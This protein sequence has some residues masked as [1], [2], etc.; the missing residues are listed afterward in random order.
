MTIDAPESWPGDVVGGVDRVRDGHGQAAARLQDAGG[1]A[2]RVRHAVDVVQAHVG[3]DQVERS[4]RER[5]PGHVTDHRGGRGRQDGRRGGQDGGGVG[6]HHRV[7]GGG[8]SPAD[9]ALAAA[10]VKGARP[11]TGSRPRNAGRFMS[12]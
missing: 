4:V 8:Q 11:G 12:S 2:D 6:G 10:Q 7:P 3:H 5:Q 9:P 1:L